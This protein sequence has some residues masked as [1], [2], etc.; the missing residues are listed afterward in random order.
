MYL[1]NR[2]H[3]ASFAFKQAVEEAGR[4]LDIQ[5]YGS[6]IDFFVVVTSNLAPEFYF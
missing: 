3:R 6:L 2:L 5:S 4:T 1:N